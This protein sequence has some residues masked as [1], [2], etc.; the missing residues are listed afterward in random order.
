MN[1]HDACDIKSAS[2]P[3][4]R[5]INLPAILTILSTSRPSFIRKYEVLVN[6]V[7]F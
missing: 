6:V 5:H 2:L 1:M 7:Y 3:K 4:L